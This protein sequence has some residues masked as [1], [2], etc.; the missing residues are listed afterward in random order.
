MPRVLFAA[1]LV[2]ELDVA[3]FGDSLFFNA[4]MS[5][6]GWF[7]GTWRVPQGAIVTLTPGSSR[8]ERWYDPHALAPVRFARDEDYVERAAELVGEAV[9]K[10]L[11]FA[12]KPAMAL[13]GGL[14]SSIV[15]SQIMR[16]L[17]LGQRLMSFTATPHPDWDGTVLPAMFGNERPWVEAFAAMHPQL[18]PTFLDWPEGGFDDCADEM[19]AAMGISPRNVANST[20]NHAVW[21]AARKAGCDTVFDAEMGNIGYS[22]DGRWAYVEYFL[23]GRWRQ[24]Y[25]TLAARSEDHRPVW[26]RIAALSILPLL[27][28]PARRAIRA[29]VH[30]EL[31]DNHR[32]VSMLRPDAVERLELA[33]RATPGGLYTGEYSTS[34]EET[35][36]RAYLGADFENCEAWQGFEQVHGLIRRDVSAYRP[37]IE[38]CLA[39][40]TDQFTRDGEDRRLARRLGIGRLPE[41]QR[42]NRLYGR[43]NADW[44][45]RL[46][47]RRAALRAE[48]EALRDDPLM[49]ELLDIDRMQAL[50]D[51]WPERTP[52]AA[53]IAMPREIGLTRA[54]MAAKFVRHLTGRNLG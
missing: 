7:C 47:R 36:R 41:A 27:P 37:L 4:N 11:A 29:I 51:D 25:R 44:H 42:T 21:A 48:A 30:P 6:E 32:F 34:R 17:P 28:R 15:A 35:I 52:M 12:R 19:F 46:T 8:V 26:R 3:R 53:D 24:L 23:T 38:Y 43:H 5:D 22:D 14:D 49:S 9:T 1:G 13:S 20:F 2:Q 10:A 50:L 40:P 18:D 31:R 39:L 54:F 45:I 16:Q 33:E